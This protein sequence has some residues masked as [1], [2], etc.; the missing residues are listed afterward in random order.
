MI[1]KVPS[2]EDLQAIAVGT[3]VSVHRE[4]QLITRIVARGT[5]FQGRD[6]VLFKTAASEGSF[7]EGSL[8]LRSG[9]DRLR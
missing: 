6:F 9:K 5:N 1:L 4:I 8:E 3:P 2:K 7:V